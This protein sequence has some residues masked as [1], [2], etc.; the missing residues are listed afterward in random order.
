MFRLSV[1]VYRCVMTFGKSKVL[2]AQESQNVRFVVNGGRPA[3]RTGLRF[4][5]PYGPAKASNREFGVC[6]LQCRRHKI[7]RSIC[8][9]LIP[10]AMIF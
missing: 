1:R 7:D 3:S 8:S 5:L 4:P 2:Y 10:K 9:R 6:G